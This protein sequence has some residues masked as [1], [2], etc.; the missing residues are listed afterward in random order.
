MKVRKQNN[1]H[2]M[3]GRMAL[4]FIVAVL[5]FIGLSVRLVF[6][7]VIDQKNHKQYISKQ[8]VNRLT[9]SI[10]QIK[11]KRGSILDRREVVFGRSDVVYK[12]IFDPRVLHEKD[13]S[14]T[15]VVTFLAKQ[16]KGVTSEGL[17]EIYETSRDKQYIP[18]GEVLTYD[19]AEPIRT[20]IEERKLV[21]VT[22]EE[23][24]VR[25]YPQKTLASNLIGFAKEGGQGQYG[26]EG[27]YEKYL[28]GHVGRRFGILDEDEAI[29]QE[30]VEAED[31]YDV[32][33]NI[34]FTVQSYIES[35]IKKFYEEEVAE[36]VR[37]IV[38]DPRNGEVLGMASYPDYDLNTP[39]DLTHILSE[40][41]IQALSSAEKINLRQ[42]LWRNK[43]IADS[44]EPG[45]TFK[46]FTVAMALEEYRV[47]LEKNRFTC[48]GSKIPF[49]GEKS[50]SCWKRTGHG[51]QTVLEA[52]T[53]SCN[54]ALMD[55]GLLVGRDFFYHY[56]Q[57]F[58][59][60]SVTNIDLPGDI[61]ARNSVYKLEE[62]DDVQLQ[63][64]AFG[65][66][67]ALTPIQLI[68][69]FSSLING[70]DLYEPQVMRKI[71]AKDGRLVLEN[72][73]V[74]QR[75]VISEEVSEEIKKMLGAV[76]DEGT[77]KRAQI[78]GYSVGGKTGT[79]EEGKRDVKEYIVSFIGF[80]P[81][82]Y[83]EVIALV[84][85]DKPEG[86]NVNSRYAAGIFKDMMTD[87]L[88]YLRIP[89]VAEVIEGEVP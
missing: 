23:S 71:I 86:E 61:S 46:P 51:E 53:N 85:V 76:V 60:G 6:I 72:E 32:I 75:K 44:Y 81:T 38:M 64:S 47:D 84:V 50:I 7:S 42:D 28:A 69:A 22:L 59:L 3:K 67:Q 13:E 63:T 78:E 2:L 56:Q 68:T 31:G 55:I 17:K 70:G 87:I 66:G 25:V 4:L 79:A 36:A 83:P 54:V 27:Y 29:Q 19:E 43:V 9:E 52:L 74:V 82:D 18:I 34:D 65:Q 16:L 40:E 45:S 10:N 37:V 62:L 26:I 1:V 20:A 21:G 15:Y 77:G 14:M 30:G 57:M 24:Y 39:Y 5:L 80:S 11:P 41:E 8:Q 88:P 49:P 12:V 35:A 58:G 89:R 73:P 33:L 48:T